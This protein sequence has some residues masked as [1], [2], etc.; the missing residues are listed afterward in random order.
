MTGSLL[1][2]TH[3]Y[4]WELRGEEDLSGMLNE[5]P[6]FVRSNLV[7]VLSP[8]SRSLRCLAEFM[9]VD[10]ENEL[11]MNVDAFCK[12]FRE[13]FSGVN[14]AYADRDIHCSWID[15]KF[16]VED[17]VEKVE[18]DEH[19]VEMELLRNGIRSLGWGFCSTDSIVLGSAIIP[20]DMIYPMIGNSSNNLYRNDLCKPINAHLTLE[21]SD[22][23]GKP[24]ECNCCD[25]ELLKLKKLPRLKPAD[26]VHTREFGNLESEALEQDKIFR[27]QFDHGNTKLRIKAVQKCNK[28]VRIEGGTSNLVLVR[29]HSGESWKSKKKNRCN[30]FADRVLEILSN[31]MGEFVHR[32][33]TPIWQVLL[34]FLCRKGYRAIVSLSNGNGESFMGILKPYTAHLALLSL[35]DDEHVMES[36]FRGLEFPKSDDNVCKLYALSHNANSASSQSGTLSS[37]NKIPLGDPIRKKNSKQV[38]QDLTW[39]SFYKAAF[40]C[41]EFELE[42]AYFACK[43]NKSKKLKFLKCW[44]KQITKGSSDCLAKPDE[45]KSGHHIEVE[46]DPR[47]TGTDQD[48]E[49]M[50]PLFSSDG[51]FKIQ[52]GTAFASCS[53]TLESFF[54]NLPKK[55]Q[56]GLESK[57]VD[58]QILAERVVNL[59]I[60]WLYQK[61]EADNTRENRSPAVKSDDSRDKII[62]GNLTKLL[63]KEPKEMKE[64]HKDNDPSISASDSG[65]TSFA[66]EKIVREY[67]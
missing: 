23:S 57:G 30:F 20:F 41:S 13:L 11:L 32:E 35:L 8:V 1:R 60:Y 7:L 64:K 48:S 10:V 26:I 65:S 47:V 17:S 59:S 62:A 4:A 18:I 45:S 31:E 2:I 39:I 37:R 40:E 9:N 28:D 58:L 50:I 3:D 49:Q 42:E 16:D 19:E 33:T 6:V 36:Q 25:L 66:L 52:G 21:I 14:D 44:V 61:N 51:P 12:K 53:E 34:S 55:I 15:V 67:P 29:T 46:I 38:F 54:S 56:D 27:G 24:L 43:F 63:L 22:V 5:S